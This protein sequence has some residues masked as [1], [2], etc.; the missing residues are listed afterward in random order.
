M[1]YR[2][3]LAYEPVKRALSVAFVSEAA[4]GPDL[5]LSRKK[6]SQLVPPGINA[7]DWTSLGSK[8][9]GSHACRPG[10]L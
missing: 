6:P 3:R 5:L 7:S 9:L 1:A 10:G 4:S 8:A 2:M